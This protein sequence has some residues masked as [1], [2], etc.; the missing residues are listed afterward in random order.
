M[1]HTEQMCS[2]E[3]LESLVILIKI[4]CNQMEEL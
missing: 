2:K 3:K 1:L 4:G